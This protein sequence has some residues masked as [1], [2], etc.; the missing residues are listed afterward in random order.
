M[1]ASQPELSALSFPELIIGIAGPI[2]VDLDQISLSFRT[3]LASVSYTSELIKLT[4]EMERFPV[5]QEDLMPDIKKW[6]GSDTFNTYM[7]KMSQSKMTIQQSLLASQSTVFKSAG[8]GTQ[9][10]ATTSGQSTATLSVS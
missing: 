2:G 10:I 5:T 6:D 9:A 1:T 4:Q 7:R 3:A 8:N